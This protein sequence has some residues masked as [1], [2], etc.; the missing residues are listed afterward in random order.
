MEEKVP[1]WYAPTINPII[2]TVTRIRFPQQEGH[3]TGFFYNSADNTYLVTNRHVLE[4]MDEAETT[5]PESVRISTRP[6]ESMGEREYHDLS[7]SE[8]EG[9]D[10][11]GFAGGEVIDVAVIPLDQDLDCVNPKIGIGN[12]R[13]LETGSIAFNEESILGEKGRVRPGDRAQ[14][15][16]YPGHYVDHTYDFPVTRNAIVST[17][18]GM[19]YNGSPMFLTDARMHPGTSGSPVLAGPVTLITHGGIDLWG[20]AYKLLGVHSATLQQPAVDGESRSLDLN[21]AWYAELIESIIS[22]V[23]E[24]N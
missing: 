6:R 10:W 21:T 22:R 2:R 18:Y 4:P 1:D 20:P 3:A 9:A 13:D 23:E 12:E 8:G 17:Q 15:V 5:A 19:P 11:Y 24:D 7:L 16:G 14:I